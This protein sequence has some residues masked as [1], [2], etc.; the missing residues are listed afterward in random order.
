MVTRPRIH[1][2]VENVGNSRQTK[3]PTPAEIT[4]LNGHER[5][6]PNVHAT[7]LLGGAVN[8]TSYHGDHKALEITVTQTVSTIVF[9]M[10]DGRRLTITKV[11]SGDPVVIVTDKSGK[12]LREGVV[13]DE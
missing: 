10:A 5:L 9:P 6:G 3:Q 2:P 12:I 4:L 7:V 8:L 13:S 11:G 1:K